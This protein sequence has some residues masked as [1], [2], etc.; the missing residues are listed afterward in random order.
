[1]DNE[2]QVRTIGDAKKYERIPREKPG[3]RSA[4]SDT[5]ITKALDELTDEPK[6]DGVTMGKVE[7]PDVTVVSG[8]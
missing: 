5:V 1:M 7:K 2:Q 3:E 4:D 6:D 8:K